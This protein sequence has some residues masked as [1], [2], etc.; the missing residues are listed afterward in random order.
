MYL[1]DLYSYIPQGRMQDFFQVL[2]NL[3]GRQWKN[4]AHH[5]WAGKIFLDS[6]ASKTAIKASKCLIF[7]NISYDVNRIKQ[8]RATANF[9]YSQINYDIFYTN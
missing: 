4:P 8:S 2:R 9:I 6:Q 5:G 1:I 7:P 3:N